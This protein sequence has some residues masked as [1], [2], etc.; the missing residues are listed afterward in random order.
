MAARASSSSLRPHSGS[1]DEHT[2][3]CKA[4]FTE[5]LNAPSPPAR[6]PRRVMARMLPPRSGCTLAAQ[7]FSLNNDV[8]TAMG[9]LVGSS[10]AI[11]ST[12]A[13]D[14]CIPHP[15]VQATRSRLRAS[16]STMTC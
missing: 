2:G 9:A 5:T 1:L 11:L 15:F 12:P 13:P 7:G 10:G 4:A 6:L 8:P 14:T 16:H 3:L